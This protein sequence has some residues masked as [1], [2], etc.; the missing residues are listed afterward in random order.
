ML[1][2]LLK[3]IMVIT[4]VGFA[5]DL[6]CQLPRVAAPEKTK[7]TPCNVLAPELFGVKTPFG[8]GDRTIEIC[9]N[10]CLY[11][12]QDLD[13][14]IFYSTNEN[15]LNTVSINP[16]AQYGHGKAKYLRTVGNILR[17]E[18]TFPHSG[19]KDINGST[20]SEYKIIE[21]HSRD[22]NKNS[23]KLFFRIGVKRSSSNS[24]FAVANTSSF[25]IPD[26]ITIAM[27]GDSFAAGE[28]APIQTSTMFTDASQL[29]N[30]KDAETTT[31][32]PCHRSYLS[33]QARAAEKAR[34]ENKKLAIVIK[35]VSCAGA[36][37]SE[38]A[39]KKQ[40][41]GS[42]ELPLQFS[43]IKTWLRDKGFAQLDILLMGIGG[44]DVGFAQAIVDFMLNPFGNFSTDEDAKKRFSDVHHGEYPF[45][46][47][48][49]SYRQLNNDILS[50]NF[51]SMST[52]GT[53]VIIH[54]YPSPCKGPDG[55]PWCGQ[56]SDWLFGTNNTVGACWGAIE[57]DDKP[58]EFKDIHNII[59]ANLNKAIEEGA[60]EN[61]W[62]FIN[63][64]NRAGNHG[65]SNCSQPYFNTLGQSISHQG[66]Y[67]GMVHPNS[68]GYLNMYVP[69]LSEAIKKQIS[70]IR[71]YW[72]GFDEQ[73][74]TANERERIVAQKQMA[75]EQAKRA[76]K[77]KALKKAYPVIKPY[78]VYRTR[79]A[80]QVDR[81]VLNFRKD[82]K[83][84]KIKL[85]SAPVQ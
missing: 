81:A 66:D 70:D 74:C 62:R 6:Y 16:A 41:S 49:E 14:I 18:Y 25:I 50:G 67:N 35:H 34:Q 44:N 42:V 73:D 24:L 80:A 77:A 36:T 71:I 60:E 47:L 58:S 63:M 82:V 30:D 7:A 79:Y 46:D 40:K 59:V 5:S 12:P 48:K 2:T 45:N 28:G 13:V 53:P 8:A 38:M 23:Q 29:W 19:F 55:S 1:P 9:I 75:V 83:D 4:M 31:D 52:V 33:G 20:A 57:Q 15:Q 78:S 26:P 22:N 32:V 84:G 56:E 65:L 27:V 61:G 17:Y 37:V 68:N 69:P 39:L 3:I 10:K 85:V 64:A 54:G 43:L 21:V 51:F 72:D 76:A 11:A